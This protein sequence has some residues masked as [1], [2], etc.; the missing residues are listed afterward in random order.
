MA[1]WIIW[2]KTVFTL[3][4]CKQ[5]TV[6]IL[7]WIVW[8]FYKNNLIYH[9]MTQKQL[10][11]CKTTNQSTNHLILSAPSTLPHM[12]NL[13]PCGS[14]LYLK[15]KLPLK[16][17]RLNWQG[18]WW[19]SLKWTLQTVLQNIREA[20]ISVSDTKESTLKGSKA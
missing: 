12:T 5:K 20:G 13:A 18:S 17:H 11:C 15:L 14:L 7:N 10:I 19:Q 1:N 6:L 16:H 8:N 9:W 2:N 3:T 4:V